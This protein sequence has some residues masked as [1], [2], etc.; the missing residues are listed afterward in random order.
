MSALLVQVDKRLRLAGCLLAAGDWPEREQ[1]QKAYRPHRLAETARRVLTPQRAHAAVQA[2]GELDPQTLFRHALAADWP[3]D[4]AERVEDF[5]ATAEV[6]QFIGDSDAEWQAAC[7]DLAGVLARTDLIE[8]LARFLDGLEHV[9]LM[10]HPNLLYPGRQA[11]AVRV[12]GQIVL[13]QPPPLAWGTSAPWRYSERPDEV[14]GAVGEGLARPLFEQA[15]VDDAAV[16]ALAA[17]VLFLRQAEGA[18]AADQ[19]MLME[20]RARKLP[21]LP[22]LVLSLERG[23]ILNRKAREE[24]E[25]KT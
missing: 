17:A 11:L 12:G 7:A 16:L 3:A 14:L 1:A 4:L 21:Q 15:G 19:F 24:R 9:S 22:A 8:F 10:V 20:G 23:Q 2:A 6:S 5:A 18:E 25:E 13:G